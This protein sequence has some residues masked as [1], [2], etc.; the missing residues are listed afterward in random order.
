MIPARGLRAALATGLVLVSGVV[1]VLVIVFV[2]LV[3][4]GEFTVS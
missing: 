4:L 1:V 2:V 3:V